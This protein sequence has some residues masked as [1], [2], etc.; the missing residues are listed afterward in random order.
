MTDSIHTTDDTAR[1][2]DSGLAGTNTK[3]D[4]SGLEPASAPAETV[5]AV[6][7]DVDAF[8]L[9]GD[10]FDDIKV[11]ITAPERSLA[12][13]EELGPSPFARGGF[14]VIGFLAATYD[15]VARYALE[16]D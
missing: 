14:P 6:E 13:L 8:W 7:P 1:H 16:R 5:E 3:D 10:G 9:C 12:L 2:E 4:P 11:E 15:K